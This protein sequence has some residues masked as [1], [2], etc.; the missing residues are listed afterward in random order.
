VS[1]WWAYTAHNLEVC[2]TSS[3]SPDLPG[4]SGRLLEAHEDDVSYEAPAVPGKSN[5]SSVLPL[6]LAVAEE[7]LVSP[8]CK[9][10]A[11]QLCRVLVREMN[12]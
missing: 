4:A 8:L 9:P 6:V 10:T 5:H 1:S 12:H 7:V 2:R 3:G 11:S